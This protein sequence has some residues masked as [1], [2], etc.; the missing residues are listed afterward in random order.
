MAKH[1]Q[2]LF[3]LNERVGMLGR[4]RYGLFSMILVGA[5]NVRSIKIN[6][7]TVRTLPHFF[8]LSYI[9]Y[10]ILTCLQEPDGRGYPLPPGACD[11]AVYSAILPLL[12]SQPFHRCTGMACSV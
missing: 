6:F 7:D 11:E 12:S 2:N 5:I 10:P 8:S 4:W 1:P 3:V 9:H